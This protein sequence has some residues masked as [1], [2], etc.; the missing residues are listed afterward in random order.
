MMNTRKL[1]PVQSIQC[2]NVV[3]FLARKNLIF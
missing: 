2:G 3:L 1:R